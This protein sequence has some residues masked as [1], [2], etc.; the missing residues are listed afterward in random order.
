MLVGQAKVYYLL[1]VITFLSMFNPSNVISQ[2]RNSQKAVVRSVL[3]IPYVPGGGHKQ[4]LDLFI[5]KEKQF[6]TLLLVHGGSLRTGDRK[7]QSEPY[8]EICKS[9]AEEGI[10]CAAMSYR[11]FPTVDWPS[12]AQDVA[13]AFAWLS[14]NISKYG[15][16]DQNLFMLGHSSGCTLAS[17]VAAD[18][19][20]LAEH[21][22][23][24]KNIAGVLA[25]G[26]RLNYNA[27]ARMEG[28]DPELVERYFREHSWGARF[29]TQEAL[30]SF[31]PMVHVGSHLPPILVLI[32]EMERFKPPILD[33]AAVFVGAARDAGVNAD[34]VILPDR[35]HYSSIRLLKSKEDSTF[36]LIKD[37]IERL[38][39]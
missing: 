27:I 10:A 11:L 21:N 8:G 7:D 25:M 22:L 14:S 33:D 32:A 13:S 9:F 35:T 15:G 1:F 16:D 36:K 31:R 37:F 29:G 24:S 5:P 26:C 17:L 19:K 6:P 39:Q 20:F 12:P 28:K 3:D 4:Q 2:N 18:Q 23:T 30:A 34:L 38:S